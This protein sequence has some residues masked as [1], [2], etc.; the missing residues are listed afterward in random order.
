MEVERAWVEEEERAPREEA[1]EKT[2]TVEE[3]EWVQDEAEEE[4]AQA[5]AEKRPA[6]TERGIR[7]KPTA[8][9]KRAAPS[10]SLITA[11]LP[12]NHSACHSFFSRNSNN[13]SNINPP[14]ATRN[15]NPSQQR[16]SIIS[17]A[18]SPS[19]AINASGGERFSYRDPCSS[20]SSSRW[21]QWFKSSSISS[22]SRW[23][24]TCN[25]IR[26]TR[27]CSRI[28]K[29][30]FLKVSSRW[31]YLISFHFIL[32]YL[33]LSY[34]IILT[35]MEYLRVLEQQQH[36]RTASYQT[37][38]IWSM[39]ITWYTTLLIQVLQLHGSRDHPSSSQL[40]SCMSK[41]CPSPTSLKARPSSSKE[42]PT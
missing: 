33:I 25:R 28:R 35:V 1:D 13:G 11:H 8:P 3:V 2:H 12:I 20:S 39:F 34:L 6:L 24:L 23:P 42:H 9:R 38:Q 41:E 22:S 17:N 31:F 14:V 27:K 16:N 32:S 21:D 7:G 26:L 19:L 29:R 18:S 37:A 15:S 30:S 10:K 36:R 5:M 40:R 4:K